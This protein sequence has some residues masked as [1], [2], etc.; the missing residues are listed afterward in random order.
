MAT[1]TSSPPCKRGFSVPLFFGSQQAKAKAARIGTEEAE[2]GTLAVTLEVTTRLQ[3]AR[4]R[5]EAE[6]QRVNALDEGVAQ[7][8]SLLRT[9]AADAFSNGDIS[10]LEWTL[11]TGQ[12]IDLS[13]ARFDALLDL[14]RAAAALDEFNDR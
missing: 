8:A 1:A 5:Y 9:A 14:S 4:Q 6:L 3:Q 7:E 12:A 2:S 13:M 10:Q 11:L